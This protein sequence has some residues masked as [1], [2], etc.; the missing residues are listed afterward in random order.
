MKLYDG[1]IT[2]PPPLWIKTKEELGNFKVSRHQDKNSFTFEQIPKD[3]KFESWTQMY[4]VY[5]WYLP[6]YDLKRFIAES[7]NAL[8]LGCKAEPKSVPVSA[9]KNAAILTYHCG[10]LVDDLVVNGNNVE[11]GFLFMGQVDHSFAKV[12]QAWRGNSKDIGTEKWYFNDQIIAKAIKNM[13]S[14]RYFKAK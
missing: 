8:A 13:E 6:E 14:I 5:A 3:Q 2:F 1:V 11:S 4:G 9:D 10:E 7:L 12:Y